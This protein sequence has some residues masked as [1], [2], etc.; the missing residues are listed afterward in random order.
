MAAA[1]DIAA[2]LAAAEWLD[3]SAQ[4]WDEGTE[5]TEGLIAARA[6][7]GEVTT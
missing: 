1:W 3:A 5:W 7:L 6:Y 2:N 4:M